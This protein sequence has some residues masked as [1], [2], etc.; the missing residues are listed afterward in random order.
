MG[1]QKG[2]TKTI[3]DIKILYALPKSIHK[4]ITGCIISFQSERNVIYLYRQIA[5]H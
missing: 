3:A 5:F 2:K 4:D 1:D